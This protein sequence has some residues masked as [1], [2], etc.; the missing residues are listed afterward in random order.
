MPYVGFINTLKNIQARFDTLSELPGAPA[1]LKEAKTTIDM[2][3]NHDL[4]IKYKD[5]S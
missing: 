5:D 1:S 4:G 2:A 3:V